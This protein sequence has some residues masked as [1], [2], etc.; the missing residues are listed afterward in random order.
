VKKLAIGCGIVVLVL[1]L[2][3]IGVSYWL[4]RKVATTVSQFAEFSSV[5]EVERQV[6]NTA[7]YEPPAS[8]ELTAAQVERL[9]QVQTLVRQRLGQR[10]EEMRTKYASLMDGNR[11]ATALDLPQLV[12]AYRDL[13]ASWMDAKRAQVEAL[14]AA[15]FSLAEYR[16]VRSQAYAALGLPV[17]EI[18]IATMVDDLKAGRTPE[19]PGR[20]GGSIGPGGPEANRTLIAPFARQLED[21]AALASFGL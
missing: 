20:I 4:F 2:A 19:A 7:A 14:N 5:P 13:A 8:G 16:W 3:G 18:D 10:F 6:R 9:V 1:A 15:G 21:N 17:M 11:E 12:A